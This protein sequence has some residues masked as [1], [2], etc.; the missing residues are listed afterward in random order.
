MPPNKNDRN[1]TADIFRVLLIFMVV[2]IHVDVFSSIK[3]L[4]FFTVDGY[5]RMAVP[6]F[7]IING[8]FFQCYVT[9]KQLFRKWL[10]RVLLLF[11][12]WQIIYLPMYFPADGLTP[13][14][15][16][17]FISELLF[18][19]HHLWYIAAMATGGI[20]LYYLKDFKK[21]LFLC[22]ALY[23]TG[24]LLQYIRVFLNA[25]GTMFKIFSQYWIFRNGLF[26]GF[27]MMYIGA[28]IAKNNLVERLSIKKCAFALILS[29]IVLSLEIGLTNHY[30]FTKMSYPIDFIISLLVFCPV[31]FIILMKNKKVYF[32][33]FKSK[34]LALLVSA[35]YFVHPYIIYLVENYHH[36]SVAV[37]YFLTLVLSFLTAM[38]LFHFRKKLFF[39]F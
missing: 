31:V 30:L 36:F 15:I 4:N 29:F 11:V 17:V 25:D 12:V 37:T 21:I 1:Q 34:D 28:Y 13:R 7:F 10:Y 16:A 8:Y 2:A 19:Y 38:I 24:W 39:I 27:P 32:T 23:L 18:G 5:F 6:I 22:V 14:H 35:V 3:E 9:D 26:F 33:H 20:I